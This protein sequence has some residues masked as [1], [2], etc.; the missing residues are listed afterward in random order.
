MKHISEFIPI[1]KFKEVDSL[2]FKHCKVCGIQYEIYH[3][4]GVCFD[5]DIARRMKAEPEFRK[6]IKAARK[7]GA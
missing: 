6:A 4:D 5:C 7:A 3:V 2:D 1:E